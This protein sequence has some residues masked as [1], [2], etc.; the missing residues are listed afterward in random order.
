MKRAIT[1]SGEPIDDATILVRGGKIVAIGKIVDVPKGAR[2]LEYGELTAMPGLVLAVSRAGYAMRS[3]PQGAATRGKD[4]ID[5]EAEI[6]DWAAKAGITTMAIVPVGTGIVGQATV[7]RPRGKT[8]D[9]MIKKEDAYLFSTFEMGTPAK[10]NFRQSFERARDAMEQFEK[11]QKDAAAS[12]PA[13]PQPS[14]APAGPPASA[15]AGGP[16]SQPATRPGGAPAGPPKLDPKIEPLVKVLKKEKKLVTQLGAAG[17]G[18][19]GGASGVAAPA[20]EVVHY[21]DAMKKFDID[22]IFTGG[23]NLALVV[24]RL[25]ELKVTVLMPTEE[26]SF[27]P[28]T[29]IRLN[30]AEE[31]HRA[32]IKVGFLPNGESRDAYQHWLYKTGQMVKMGFP[33]KEALRAITLIPAEYLGMG[34][35]VGSLA[36]GREADI[37]FIDGA[38]FDASTKVV[39]VMI[40]GEMLEEGDKQ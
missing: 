26:T 12:Q 6:Y 35:Q 8:V 19:F 23:A 5:P 27:E 16:A 31:L 13:Q 18:G 1:V 36:T 25:K 22:R 28:Y 32:G 14:G 34:D 38:P 2:R 33:E 9:E 10:D 39:H 24:D 7:I 40:G 37:L 3:M 17:G 4:G 11:V 30:G 20:A 15:P 29:R 21:Q